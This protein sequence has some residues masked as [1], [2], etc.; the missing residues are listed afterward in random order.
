MTGQTPHGER[1]KRVPELRT[2]YPL[3]E[4]LHARSL[5]RSQPTD[6]TPES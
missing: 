3:L 6:M 1:P 4:Y 5:S 2:P